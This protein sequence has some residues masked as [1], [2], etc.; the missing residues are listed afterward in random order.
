MGAEVTS[1]KMVDGT[2]TPI[3]LDD[4]GEASL[5]YLACMTFT[6]DMFEHI[7]AQSRLY[8]YTYL[9]FVMV[10]VV[11]CRLVATEAL[12]E[13]VPNR[14]QLNPIETVKFNISSNFN[15]IQNHILQCDGQM[16]C[17]EFQIYST[18]EILHT[19]ST[20]YAATSVFYTEFKFSEH[21]NLW[22]FWWFWNGN[23]VSFC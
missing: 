4:H 12:L 21:L 7:E 18:E 19:V 10:W 1:L 23:Q 5:Y 17:V 6:F 9:I 11:A 22:I 2:R 15:L 20:P 3:P 13:P 14:C 16:I 8:V